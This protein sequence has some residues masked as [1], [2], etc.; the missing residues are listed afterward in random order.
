MKYLFLDTS[1][2][3]IVVAILED[4]RILF[5]FEDTNDNKLSERIMPI[6][7]D[8]FSQTKLKPN[9]INTIFV[10][11]GPGS[12]TGIRVGVT[13]AK[14][15]AWA[16][17]IKVIPISE[18]E[19]MAT[20]SF[21][22]DYIVS[23]IDARRDYVYAGVYD[24]NLNSIIKD[25]HILL[26][27]LMDRLPDDKEIIFTSHDDFDFNTIKTKY[28]IKKIIDKHLNDE[29]INPHELNPNYLKLTE[30]EEKLINDKNN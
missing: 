18:L 26:D 17:K 8:A 9:D 30:A 23:L 29:G 2:S 27:Y 21:D 12:F 14:I 20:T 4:K 3:R 25:S 7:N 13:I 15:M 22:G 10:V 1:A 11:N 16:L 5:Y 28:D 6:I 24:H 19:F